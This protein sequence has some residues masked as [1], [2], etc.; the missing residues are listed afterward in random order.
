MNKDRAYRIF[1]WSLLIFFGGMITLGI[2]I[3]INKDAD[4]GGQQVS[5][6]DCTILDKYDKKATRG[7]ASDR[8]Y[9]IESSCGTFRANTKDISDEVEVGQVCD[10]YVTVGNWA[11]KP[12]IISV[13]VVTDSQ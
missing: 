5:H 2:V 4:L 12:T 9:F 10:L 6:T 3:G 11:N 7:L 13:E 1:L 8:N